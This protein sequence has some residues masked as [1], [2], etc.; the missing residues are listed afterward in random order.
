M[1]VKSIRKVKKI[2]GKRV[3]L[4]ADFNVPMEDGE[5]KDDFKIVT[6]LETIRYLLRYKCKLIIISHLGRPGGKIKKGL[7]LKPI[8]KKLERYLG[9]KIIFINEI[10]GFKAGNAVSKMK[11]GDIVML[12]NVRFKKDEITNSKKFA[13][14]LANLGEIYVNDAF[15]ADHRK[16]ASLAAIQNLMPAYAGFVLTKEITN[17]DRIL[18]PK[19][20]LVVILGGAKIA[21]KLKL[22][23]K[24]KQAAKILIGGALAN[25]FL[26]AH[27]FEIG[28][29][30]YDKKSLSTA[31]RLKQANLILPIDVIVSQ[32]NSKINIA[33]KKINAIDKKDIILDIGPETMRLYAKFIKQANT[34]IWNG[35]MGM[36]EW[37]K[38]KQGT[39]VIAR[40]VASRSSGKAFGVVGGGETIAA[41]KMA[42]MSEYV[43]WISTG[44]GA[45][46][47]YLGGEKL[48]GFVKIVK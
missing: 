33:V 10:N 8:A 36:F 46:L 24:F 6:G 45:M 38:F 28:K 39:M 1:K 32:T 11:A 23:K 17:L 27:N 41:L 7:S 26:K 19:K 34:L 9:K 43:D 2:A 20:P 35:P 12:E 47:T 25:N 14:Q 48:P 3:I 44:G 30:L 5:I 42:N 13:Q 18:K 40:L 21:T 15:A 4:R 29:S 31:K 16:H 22:I 37:D